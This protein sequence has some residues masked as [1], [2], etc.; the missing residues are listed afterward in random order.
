M[1]EAKSNMQLCQHYIAP[2]SHLHDEEGKDGHWPQPA[3]Y[4]G[5]RRLRAT[6]AAHVLTSSIF[7]ACFFNNGFHS[8]R[9]I[10]A[11]SRKY[12]AKTRRKSKKK[13]SGKFVRKSCVRVRFLSQVKSTER[14]E[15]NEQ[16][17]CVRFRFEAK[18]LTEKANVQAN[19]QFLQPARKRNN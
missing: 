17:S 5:L 16:K 14:K 3:A 12:T 13:L 8:I 2:W 9:N 15:K 11:F 7:V 4:G 10:R 19:V 6:Y 18:I 1:S